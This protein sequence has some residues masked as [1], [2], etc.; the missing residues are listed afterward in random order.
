[1]DEFVNNHPEIEDFQHNLFFRNE[2][3][4]RMMNLAGM[5]AYKKQ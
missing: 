1:M 5:L 4:L 3:D 2:F